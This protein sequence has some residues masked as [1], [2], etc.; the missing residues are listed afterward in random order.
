MEKKEIEKYLSDKCDRIEGFFADGLSSMNTL[1]LITDIYN[2]GK[3]EAYQK[4]QQQPDKF[5]TWYHSHP[6]NKHYVGEQLIKKYKKD[7]GV[8]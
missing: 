7:N 3:N 2:E 1:K 8:L 6:D 5:L 4:P